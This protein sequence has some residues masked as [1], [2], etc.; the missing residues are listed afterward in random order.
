MGTVVVG[1][2]DQ[3]SVI[4]EAAAMLDRITYELGDVTDLEAYAKPR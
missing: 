4:R 2:A 1:M 3:Q